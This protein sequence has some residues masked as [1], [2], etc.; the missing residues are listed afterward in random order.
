MAASPNETAGAMKVVTEV[1][2]SSV[3]ADPKEELLT[4]PS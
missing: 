1:A 4:W 2:G 3:R